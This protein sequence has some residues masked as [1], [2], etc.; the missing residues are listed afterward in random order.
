MLCLSCL[1]HKK[2]LMMY[3]IRITQIQEYHLSHTY[4]NLMMYLICKYIYRNFMPYLIC[5][6]E[7]LRRNSSR[8]PRW[9][10]RC[11]NTSSR[12][13]RPR[14]WTWMTCSASWRTTAWTSSTRLRRHSTRSTPSSHCSTSSWTKTWW[15]QGLSLPD[16]S[17]ALTAWLIRGSHCPTLSLNVMIRIQYSRYEYFKNENKIE[18]I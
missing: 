12:W 3:L 13:C 10:S 7:I 5:I 11:V 6:S 4:K 16:L 8:W 14:T 18:N 2:N 17:E 15:V 9:S 1:T